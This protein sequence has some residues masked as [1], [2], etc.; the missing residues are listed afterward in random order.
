MNIGAIGSNSFIPYTA[1]AVSNS[2]AVTA[3]GEPKPIV[4]PGESN[5]VQPGK[6]SSPAQCQTC[7]N[8]KYQDGS[9][10][11]VSY[12][13]ATHISAQASLGRVMAHEQEHVSNAHAKAAKSGGQVMQASVSIK[14]AICPECGRAYAA[15]GT[16]TTA[17]K[18]PKDR[19]SQ[20]RKSFE[21]QAA[22]GGNFDAAV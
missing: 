14:M 20:N 8:R 13:S 6:K 16:T 10:E 19:V 7:K 5:E 1:G 2:G 12:K 11:M 4:N 15:G 9:N 17:I 21:S 3:T 18:Y 22:I